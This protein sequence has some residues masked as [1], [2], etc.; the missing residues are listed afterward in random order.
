MSEATKSCG[1]QLDDILK[2]L[3]EKFGSKIDYLN[4]MIKACSKISAKENKHL[5]LFYLIIPALSINYVQFMARGKQQINK[6][7]STKAFLYDDGFTL[8]VS[9]FINLLKQ[10]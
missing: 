8:G 2:S 3:D 6:K 9:F 5:K 4:L 1:K 7:I 10:H